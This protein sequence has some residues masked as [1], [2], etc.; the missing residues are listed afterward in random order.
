MVVLKTGYKTMK[1]IFLLF[2]FAL[3]IS[4]FATSGACSSHGG[5]NCSAG[6]SYYAVCNDGTVS[7]TLYYLTDECSSYP[8]SS[9]V[10]PYATGY[11]DEN[12]CGG[13]AVQANLYGMAGTAQDSS[14]L[15]RQQVSEYKA[16]VSAYNNCLSQESA[17]KTQASQA[18]IDSLKKEMNDAIDKVCSDAHPFTKKD[19]YSNACICIDGY[20]M[21]AGQCVPR[22]EFICYQD[23]GDNAQMVNGN[24]GCKQGYYQNQNDQCV[25]GVKP[26]IAMTASMKKYL[27]FGNRCFSNQSFT[28]T[29]L[30]VCTTYESNPKYYDVVI[31]DSLNA[32]DSAKTVTTTSTG[33]VVSGVLPKLTFARS[34]KKGMTGDD[35]KQLQILL[36][37]LN[38]LTSTQTP[39]TYFGSVTSNA[40]IKFQRDNNIQPATGFFGPTT[41]AKILSKIN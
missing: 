13:L 8:V 31:V 38:Y 3:P 21:H 17:Q 9:C 35:V 34:L 7:N 25:Y 41:Q 18:R 29:E 22:N 11:T 28:Q 19:P 5:V 2:I 12:V 14:A 32:T 16:K 40:L 4:A 30:Q 23:Y 10:Y 37:K 15:C 26:K 6:A 1:K 36:Q 20:Q 27:D 33:S 39:S 24:C